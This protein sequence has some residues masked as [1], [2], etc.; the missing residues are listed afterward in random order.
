MSA[1]L[2]GDN[3][4]RGQTEQIR[5]SCVPGAAVTRLGSTDYQTALMLFDCQTG[6]RGAG[7]AR[8]RNPSLS[9]L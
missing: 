8:G 2:Y 4:V 9:T 6:L 3:H 1:P 5:Q 7:E